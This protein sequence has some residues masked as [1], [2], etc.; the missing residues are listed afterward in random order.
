MRTG[1]LRGLRWSHIDRE[2][3]VIRLPAELTKEK[4][5]KVIPINH[6]VKV[7]LAELPRAIHHDSVLTYRRTCRQPWRNKKIR[8]YRPVE[9]LESTMVGNATDGNIFHDIRRSVKTN[10][11]NAG[12]DKVHRDTIIGHALH[13]MD[14]HYIVSL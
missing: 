6:N 12:V 13:G 2:K 5:A 9:R 3:W 14:V 7:V 11:L 10:M 1:E 4:R 8:L